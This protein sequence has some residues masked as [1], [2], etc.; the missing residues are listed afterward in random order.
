LEG[1]QSDGVTQSDFLPRLAAAR[2]LGPLRDGL[3]AAS[4]GTGGRKQ[5]QPTLGTQFCVQLNTL[6]SKLNATTPHFI[7]CLKP[8]MHKRPAAFNADEI[9][10]QLRYTG[11]VGLCRIRQIGYPERIPFADFL[12]RCA[13]HT[14]TRISPSRKVLS[15]DKR[16]EPMILREVV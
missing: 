1:L 5:R 12:V 16:R 11:I 9:L 4:T 2:R 10:T 13:L 15:V 14:T 7:K 8:N 6:M 3:A